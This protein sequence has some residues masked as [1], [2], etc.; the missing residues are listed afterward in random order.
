MRTLLAAAATL[1]ATTAAR[2][3]VTAPPPPPLIGVTASATIKPVKGFIDDPVAFDGAR[4]AYVNTDSATFTDLV[5]FDVAG[6]KELVRTPLPADL[7]DPSALDFAGPR[8]VLVTRDEDASA[9]A[10]VF[11]ADGQL[12]RKIGPAADI[13]LVTIGGQPRLALHRTKVKNQTTTH[14]LELVDLDKGKRVGKLRTLDA[15]AR[16]KVARLDF[17]I[18]HWTDGFTHAVGTKGGHWDPKEDQRTP[19]VYADYDLTTGAF[20]TAPI[21]DPLA[22][23]H[24]FQVGA[25]RPKGWRS[26]FVRMSDD[27]ASVELWQHGVPKPITLDQPLGQYLAHSF[28]GGLQPDGTIWIAIVVDPVNPAA[29]KRKVADPEYTDL[30]KVD[31]AAGTATRVARVLAPRKQHLWGVN[32]KQWWMLERSNGWSHGGTQ[33][34]VYAI[35]SP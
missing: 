7:G 23:A 9:R 15:D 4:L 10:A 32:G 27:L 22:M 18:N 16:G 24:R 26:T 6:A 21:D 29:V 19:D 20:T 3:D 34:T 13:T 14:E 2:A 17:T 35:N 31:A 12:Q 33:L 1:I 30:Y 11:G 28:S 8:L 5:V 25:A